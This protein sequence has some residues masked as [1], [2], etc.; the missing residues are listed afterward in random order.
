MQIAQAPIV[1]D[2][3]IVYHSAVKYTALAMGEAEAKQADF[4]LAQQFQDN[5]Q[6]YLEAAKAFRDKHVSEF[7]KAAGPDVGVELGRAL[8]SNTSQNYKT[9]VLKQQAKIKSD[10]D[11]ATTA[12]I[13]SLD[14]DID[15]LIKSGD[16][17]SPQLKALIDQRVATTKMRVQNPILGEPAEVAALDLK[18]FDTKVGGAQFVAGLN[19][20][21]AHP[22]GGISVAQQVVN[23]QLKDTKLPPAQ[24]AYNYAQGQE[25]IK[26]YQQNLTRQININEKVQKAKDQSFEDAV[27]KDSAGANPT[28]T[29]N[30]IKTAPGISPEARMRMLAWQKRDGMPEPMAKVSQATATDLFRRMDLPDDDPAHLSDLRDV[31]AAYADGK[32]TRADEEWLEKRF[33]Q[34]RSPEGTQLNKLR[35]ELSKAAAPMLDKSTLM[36]IDGEGKLRTYNYERFV[37]SKINEYRAE[38]K[39]PMDLFDPSNPDFV[40]KPAVINQFSTPLDQ[41]ITN[42]VRRMTGGGAAAPAGTAPAGPPQRQPGETPAAYMKRTG[43]AP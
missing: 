37:D 13:Q 12:K 35:A 28:I 29:E 31:R 1:G 36:N 26:E 16:Q 22:D 32:L 25:A 43:G 5:P 18:K 6:G 24:R 20:I 19:R 3:A 41:Q 15:S 34:G 14:V 7:A 33:V 4:K 27:V 42:R 2:A 17:G 21:M 11:A 9:L 10:F 39:N 8:D 23:D 30:D 38:K 40:G